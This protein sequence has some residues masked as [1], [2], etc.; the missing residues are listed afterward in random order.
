ML[1]V[2]CGAGA[3]GLE[4]INRQS[5]DMYGVE[6][7]ALKAEIAKAYYKEVIETKADEYPWSEK[8]AFLML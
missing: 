6:A 7:D 4:L 2:G 1:D 5:A 3:T 8:E